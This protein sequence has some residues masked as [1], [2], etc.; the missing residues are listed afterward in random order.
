LLLPEMP[1]YVFEAAGPVAKQIRFVAPSGAILDVFRGGIPRHT[2]RVAGMD[3]AL[4]GSRG[5]A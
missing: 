2:C 5:C 4:S 3:A 1:Q